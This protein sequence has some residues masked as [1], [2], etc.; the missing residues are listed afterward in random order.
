MKA[1]ENTELDKLKQKVGIQLLW[2]YVLALLKKAPSHAYTLR[3]Q[4]QLAFGFLPGNVPVYVSLY[5]LKKQE[6]VKNSKQGK[7]KVYE[8]TPKGEQVLEEAKKIFDE[9]SKQWFG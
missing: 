1:P 2:L 4:I 5:E 7:R 8:I 9:K 6:L 3:K